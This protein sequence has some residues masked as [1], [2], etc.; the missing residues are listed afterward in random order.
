MKIDT[1]RRDRAPG[2][3]SFGCVGVFINIVRVNIQVGL[4]YRISL[5]AEGD[6]VMINCRIL[7]RCLVL[8]EEC[9]RYISREYIER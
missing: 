9:P 5:S 6:H 4:N 7:H 2:F 1:L 3:E 8:V